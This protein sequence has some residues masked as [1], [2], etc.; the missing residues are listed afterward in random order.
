MIRSARL[1]WAAAAFTLLSGAAGG[2]LGLLSNVLYVGEYAGGRGPAH[3]VLGLDVGAALG[4]ATGLATGLGWC[5]LMVQRGE[6][7]RRRGHRRRLLAPAI[8]GGLVAGSVTALLLHTGMQVV[9]GSNSPV[10]AHAVG[11]VIGLAAGALI[12]LVGGW[13]WPPVA[14]GPPDR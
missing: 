14:L 7:A 1:W 6:A 2:F 12:G 10:T 9:Y 3:Q 13:I 4:M 8:G 5:W 11:Q